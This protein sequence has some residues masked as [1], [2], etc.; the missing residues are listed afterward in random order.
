MARRT[1]N[2]VAETNLGLPVYDGLQQMAGALGIPVSILQAARKAGCTFMLHGR[3]HAGTFIRWYFEQ[4]LTDD[5][6][7]NWTKRD[8]RASAL[9]RELK[10]ERS[11]G[12]VIDRAM[13]EQILTDVIGNCFSGELKRIAQ[14]FP[15]VLKGKSE[16]EIHAEC[17]RQADAI[18]A[19]FES[20]LAAWVAAMSKGAE[21]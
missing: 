2:T 17:E 12:S 18:K 1:R 9:M 16:V 3:A 20:R 15:A 5:E 4:N 10:L 19:R 7:E 21:E 8:K 13:V 14:E 6:R 11:R